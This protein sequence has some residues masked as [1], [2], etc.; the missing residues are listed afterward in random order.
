MTDIRLVIEIQKNFGFP[1]YNL[2]FFV[3]FV[4]FAPAIFATCFYIIIDRLANPMLGRA[5]HFYVVCVVS[6]RKKNLR[7]EKSKFFTHHFCFEAISLH[8]RFFPFFTATGWPIDMD[9][10]KSYPS[11]H[12]YPIGL[13]KIRLETY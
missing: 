11:A 10:K 3:F 9:P 12:C 4:R 7:I 8:K 2:P 1:A 13:E 6:S 5:Q